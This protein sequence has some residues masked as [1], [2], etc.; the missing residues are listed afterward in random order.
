M[1][2]QRSQLCLRYSHKSHWRMREKRKKMIRFCYHTQLYQNIN[3]RW[4]FAFVLWVM[5]CWW[6]RSLRM[7]RIFHLCTFCNW[8]TQWERWRLRCQCSV[9]FFCLIFLYIAWGSSL[10]SSQKENASHTKK[11]RLLAMKQQLLLNSNSF[12]SN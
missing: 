1:I 9:G 10:C 6:V 5:R 8:G 3:L 4:M 7:G 2:A 11:G 12:F